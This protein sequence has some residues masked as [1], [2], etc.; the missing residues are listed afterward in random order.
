VAGAAGP[1]I[2]VAAVAALA[3]IIAPANIATVHRDIIAVL[4]TLPN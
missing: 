4:H 2:D 1:V 3:A